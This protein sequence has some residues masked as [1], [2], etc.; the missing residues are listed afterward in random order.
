MFVDL[1]I[2]TLAMRPMRFTRPGGLS[3]AANNVWE[4]GAGTPAPVM[5]NWAHDKKRKPEFGE[6]AGHY[7]IDTT[8][9][10]SAGIRRLPRVAS[11]AT[12]RP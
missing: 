10:A 12:L 2:S 3:P 9:K 1:S 7:V 8:L 4:T 5:S 11:T 6:T